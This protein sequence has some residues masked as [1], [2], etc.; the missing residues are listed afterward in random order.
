[1]L[2]DEDITKVL[3]EEKKKLEIEEVVRV[4][5]G[6]KPVPCI[7]KRGEE[8]TIIIPSHINPTKIRFKHI[9]RHELYHSYRHKKDVERGVGFMRNLLLDIPANVYSYFGIRL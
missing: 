6:W 8:Y 5:P 9:I 7:E 3:E 4:F 1:M 2:I